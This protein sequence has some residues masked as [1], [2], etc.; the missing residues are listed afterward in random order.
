MGSCTSKPVSEKAPTVSG[1]TRTGNKTSVPV[2]P[3]G[4]GKPVGSGG[5]RLGSNDDSGTPNP[6]TKE[7]VA[8]AA[9]QRYDQHQRQLKES[10]SRLG[11]LSKV[12]RAE[13]G[14]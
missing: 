13:K 1:A 12:S 7:A 9:Q 6:N 3:S 4:N 8:K 10:S 14:L 5:V 11:A 2:K